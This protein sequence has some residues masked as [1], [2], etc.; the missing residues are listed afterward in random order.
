MLMAI[1]NELIHGNKKRDR[2]IAPEDMR[3]VLGYHSRLSRHTK[4]DQ[5]ESDFEPARSMAL[6]LPRVGEPVP[7]G[8]FEYQ[9]N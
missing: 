5:V 1:L 2:T 8:R 4:H 6:V 7:V 9:Q 3:T